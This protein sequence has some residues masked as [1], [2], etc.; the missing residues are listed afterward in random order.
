MVYLPTFGYHK[1]QPNVGKYT[2]HVCYGILSIKSLVAKSPTFPYSTP[3]VPD[4]NPPDLKFSSLLTT[5]NVSFHDSGFKFHVRKTSNNQG[6]SPK[7]ITTIP[8]PDFF[9]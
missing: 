6:S 9:F 5:T 2:I 3:K 7:L 1:N 8:K 4:S